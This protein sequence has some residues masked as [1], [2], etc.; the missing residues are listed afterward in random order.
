[1]AATGVDFNTAVQIV[2]GEVPK[3][4]V[5]QRDWSAIMSSADPLA[6]AQASTAAMYNSDTASLTQYQPANVVASTANFA[7]V[8]QSGGPSYVALTDSMGN[9]VSMD[10]SPA[11]L[12][13]DATDYGFDLSQLSALEAKLV[14]ANVNYQQGAWINGFL[15]T[16]QA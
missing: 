3:N 5:D 13:K 10:T 2:Y 8:S 16:S 1:M 15:P 6:S 14:A 9:V 4:G 11:A 7:F 12:A